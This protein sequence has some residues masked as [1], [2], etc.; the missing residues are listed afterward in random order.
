MSETPVIIPY[1][2]LS[3][4]ALRGVIEDFVNREGTDYGERVYDLEEKVNHVMVQLQKGKVHIVFDA[5]TQSCSI[6]TEQQA[7]KLGV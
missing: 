3:P 6:I 4:E 2:R 5:Q 1:E 7:K